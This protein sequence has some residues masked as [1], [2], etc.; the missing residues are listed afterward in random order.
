MRRVVTD[1]VR[2]MY[3]PAAAHGATLQA[4]KA[5]GARELARWKER[6]VRSWPGVTMRALSDAPRELARAGRLELRVAV[7]LNGLGPGDVAVEFCGKRLLP[8]DGTERP[9]LCSFAYQPDGDSWR[10]RLTPDGA[11]ESDGSHV[12]VLDSAPPS[13]GQFSTEIRIRPE[14]GL[15]SHPLELGLLKRL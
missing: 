5:A 4:G 10:A 2:S 8:R 6:V 3:R 7:A 1:Y 11:V 14:H 15:L 9:P 12:Y 13:A